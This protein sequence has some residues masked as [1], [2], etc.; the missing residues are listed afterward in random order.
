MKTRTSIEE[1]PVFST[2]SLDTWYQSSKFFIFRCFPSSSKNAVT[3]LISSQYP[4][5]NWSNSHKFQGCSF[6]LQIHMNKPYRRSSKHWR[7]N[8]YREIRAQS[9]A[10]TGKY[11][12]TS[13]IHYI[14]FLN[15]IPV[16][17]FLNIVLLSKP[18]KEFSMS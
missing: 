15:V 4:R 8:H 3:L 6:Q 18:F 10:V 2:C 1:Y 7:V 5:G 17:P 14:Y 9:L 16:L 13:F 12:R 11:T